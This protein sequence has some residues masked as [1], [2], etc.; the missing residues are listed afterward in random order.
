MNKASFIQF[1]ADRLV[2]NLARFVWQMHILSAMVLWFALRGHVDPTILTFWAIWMWGW[3]LAQGWISFKGSA[4]AKQEL[5]LQHWPRLF[6]L[7]AI[8]AALGYGYIGFALIPENNEP[9][10]VFVGFVISGGIL[11]GTGT[12]NMHYPM[13]VVTLLIIIPAQAA[14]VL[15]ENVGGQGGIAAGMLLA[16]MGLM[17]GLGWVLRTFTRRGFELQWEKTQ[18]ADALAVAKAE[19][20]DANL[21]KSRFLAQASHDLRQPI[22]SMGLFL[23]S[24]EREKL[25]DAGLAITNRISQSVDI[26]AKLF[27]AL[28]D[29]TLLDSGKLAPKLE[30]VGLRRLVDEVVLEF[31]PAAMAEGCQ[32]NATGADMAIKSDPVL[33]RRI[34]QNLVSNAI[35]HGEGEITIEITRHEDAAYLSVQDN[36]PGIAEAERERMYEMFERPG[37]I[38]DAADGL[39]LG[40]AIVRRLASAL[41]TEVRLDPSSTRGAR[42]LVGPL[43]ITSEYIPDPAQE[44]PPEAIARL[45]R[46]LV[47]DDSRATLEATGSLLEHWGWET[48]TYTSLDDE[49]ASKLGDIDLVITDYELGLG[50]T[51]LDTVQLIRKYAPNCPAVVITGSS[52]EQVQEAVQEA[53]LLLLLKPVRPIQLRSAIL[54]LVGR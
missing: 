3:G 53:G 16:F 13:L 35:R 22:H 27:N 10:G 4:I 51:G 9:L 49:A 7:T 11:T 38:S 19:A 42:F 2:L 31:E 1:N 5:P 48:E 32:L 24:L 44:K 45:G 8:M 15:I 46:V 14:R 54:S 52:T 39:G 25:S 12:H 40:L 50:Q 20:E 18:L 26:L 41:E 17:L 23:A 6:D 21:A 36:G 33:M 37:G 43:S 28:L 29:V 47:I 30:A 34:I